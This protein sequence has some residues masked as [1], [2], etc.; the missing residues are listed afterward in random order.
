MVRTYE[1][2]SWFFCV[3]GN[4]VVRAPEASHVWTFHPSSDGDCFA[5]LSTFTSVATCRN[6]MYQKDL[7]YTR[8]RS[9][10]CWND[11]VDF[12]L[13]PCHFILV[14]CILFQCHSCSFWDIALHFFVYSNTSPFTMFL[15]H[16]ELCC[17]FLLRT[18]LSK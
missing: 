8:K 2:C 18:I 12:G 3:F 9:K 10:L 5:L 13:L 16:W 14:H 11:T 17:L 15:A 7:E 1:G 4:T 6:E